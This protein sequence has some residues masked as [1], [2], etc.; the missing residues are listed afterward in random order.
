MDN[1]VLNHEVMHTIQVGLMS[2]I[3]EGHSEVS[4]FL[5]S[6]LR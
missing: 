6:S 3:Y 1:L 2:L 4:F 5:Y